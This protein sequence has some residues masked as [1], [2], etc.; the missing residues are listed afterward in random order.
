MGYD[1]GDPIA[2]TFTVKVDGTLTNATVAITVTDP[3]GLTSTPAISNP[4]VGLYKAVFTGSKV[5]K[6][7]WKWTASG[8]ASGVEHGYAIVLADP[9]TRLDP[10]ATF[11][12]LEESLGRALT[13]AEQERAPALLRAASA[14]ARRYAR[15]LFTKVT[16]D[17]VVL[18][19]DGGRL[20]LPQRPV[21]AVTAVKAVGAAGAP[22]LTV[23]G[24]SWD[25]LDVINLSTASWIINMPEDWEDVDRYP[26]TYRVTYSHG[27]EPI[28]DDVISVVAGA[29]LRTLSAPTTAGDVVGETIGA[30]SYRLASA[31]GG[32]TVRLT[33]EDKADLRH[34][35]RPGASLRM[36]SVWT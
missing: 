10:L 18:V 27:Y 34:Y 11:E 3:D 4:S 12:D 33:D 1:L 32:V 36:R 30:Y 31:N 26:G 25:Q 21:T 20:V 23:T 15:Q 5:G 6:W 19:A 9:P 24:W 8:A 22:D 14:K 35:R 28:P 7:R 2:T 13:T 16:D 17:V 29:V